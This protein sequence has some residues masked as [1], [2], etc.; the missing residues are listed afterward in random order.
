MS[1]RDDNMKTEGQV[2]AKHSVKVQTKLNLIKD[3]SA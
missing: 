2:I 1:D 3:Q